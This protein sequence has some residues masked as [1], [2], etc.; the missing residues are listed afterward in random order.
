MASNNYKIGLCTLYSGVPAHLH[1]F[2][3]KTYSIFIIKYYIYIS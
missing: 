2:I 1:Q 3:K